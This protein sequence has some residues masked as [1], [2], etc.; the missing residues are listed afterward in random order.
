MTG[1]KKIILGLAIALVAI[2]FI[3]PD[4]NAGVA[5]SDKDITHALSVPADVKNILVTSC[6]DC[7]SN[8]TEPMWYMNLQPVGWWIGH[9]IKEGKDELNFSE[10]AGYSPKR[11]AHKLEE[12]AEQIERKEMPLSSYT[13]VHGNAKL[14]PEQADILM[15][16]AK[17]GHD[18]IKA[19][20]PP[21]PPGGEHKSEHHG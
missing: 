20:L 1:K 4:A 8:H 15:K 21:T 10:F 12:V 3:R 5:D 14:S 13:W 9:H 2:Q 11:Q 17:A 16:W 19:K 18:S 7:H 6:Y